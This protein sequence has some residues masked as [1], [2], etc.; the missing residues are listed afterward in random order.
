MYIILARRKKFYAKLICKLLNAPVMHAFII[1]KDVFWNVWMALEIDEQGTR[2]CLFDSI[3]NNYDYFEY[4]RCPTCCFYLLPVMKTHLNKK[5][6]YLKLI[7]N[8]GRLIVDKLFKKKILKTFDRTSKFICTEFVTFFL[9]K[10]GIVDTQNLI[11]SL[12]SPKT[13]QTF[14]QKNEQFIK[15]K[16]PTIV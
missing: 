14:L 7:I 9:K 12:T 13:L 1:Y 3:K 2:I 5:Y 10:T 15:T 16:N 11:P 4:Y 8:I 6:D